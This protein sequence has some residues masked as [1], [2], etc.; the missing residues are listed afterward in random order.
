VVG[1]SAQARQAK[2]TGIPQRRPPPAARDLL[3]ESVADRLRPLEPALL[4][5]VKR[6]RRAST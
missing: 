3:I 2:L 6:K 4:S 1:L 5:E